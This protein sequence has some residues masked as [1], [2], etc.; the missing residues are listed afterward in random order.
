MNSYREIKVVIAG[1]GYVGRGLTDL[2][3]A[4]RTRIAKECGLYFSVVAVADAGGIAICPQGF[5]LAKLHTIA[6]DTGSVAHYPEYGQRHLTAL[7]AIE[8]SGAQMMVECTTSDYNNAEPAITHVMQALSLSMDIVLANKGPLAL[9]DLPI[10]E[11]GRRYGKGIAYSCAAGTGLE[12]LPLLSSLADAGELLGIRGIFNATSEYI[13]RQLQQGIPFADAV[14]AAQ[15]AGFA[16]K[17]PSLDIQG[18]DSAVKL[19]I[20]SNHAWGR[21]KTIRDIQITGIEGL[22]ASDIRHAA[23]AG[24]RYSLVA[25]AEENEGDYTLKV[26]P[27]LLQGDDP[28]ARI[29]WKDKVIELNTRTQGRQL[30]YGLGG[31]A[32]SAAGSVLADMLRLSLTYR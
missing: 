14:T 3:L 2:I 7:E 8:L 12:V 23:V 4:E 30:L 11:A 27:C 25:E 20:Q 13:L 26:A 10:R 1:Y 17:D 9:F 24:N 15:Q 21:G 29:T 28:L 5:P 18:F 6:W 16:E 19:L 22:S 31:S 32:S